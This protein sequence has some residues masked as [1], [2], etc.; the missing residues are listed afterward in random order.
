MKRKNIFLLFI[1]FIPLLSFI[2]FYI[3]ISINFNISNKSFP[4]TI[5]KFSL[6]K[7]NEKEFN[8]D[9]WPKSIVKK[10]YGEYF[11]ISVYKKA[12]YDFFYP[13][14]V[15]ILVLFLISSIISYLILLKYL[16]RIKSGDN[17]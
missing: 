4:L 11:I 3:F 12:F 5:E 9:I 1:I 17:H 13:Y 14:L 8:T 6:E 15:F 10:Q 2:V 7:I 16:N